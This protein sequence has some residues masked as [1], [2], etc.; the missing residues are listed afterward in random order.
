MSLSRIAAVALLVTP[1]VAGLAAAQ[2]AGSVQVNIV[3]AHEV[4]DLEPVDPANAFPADV[5][6]VAAWTRVTGAANTTIEHVWRHADHE[7]VV[8]LSIG[9]SPWRTWSTKVI[10]EE[11]TGEWTFEVRANG[12]VVASTTF[13]VGT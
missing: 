5:G 10:P 9:G 8:P 4:V 2:E 12:A 1:T 13:T 7:F 3:I 6:R 11:W